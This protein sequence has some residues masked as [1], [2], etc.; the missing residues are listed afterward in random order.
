MPE[1]KFVIESK[2]YFDSNGRM[3]CDTVA[4]NSSQKV[5]K[6]L[7]LDDY[8][9]LLADTR[10]VSVTINTSS[11]Y[12]PYGT[13]ATREGTNG[14]ILYY[15]KPHK[16]LLSYKDK[17]YRVAYPATIFL[18]SKTGSTYVYAVKESSFEKVTTS[19]KLYQ[20][21]FGHVYTS[22]SVCTGSVVLKMGHFSDAPELA[23]KFFNAENSH[24]NNGTNV[25]SILHK[26]EGKDKFPVSLLN[27]EVQN[28]ETTV[29]SLVA[30]Y[31]T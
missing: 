20:W 12:L 14:A 18:F 3:F 2:L 28:K 30:T 25:S 9:N 27:K 21:P 29:G 1:K 7:T 31:F 26:L 22:G 17:L 13:I 4:G 11:G 19:T 15:V 6:T 8:I 24:T 10:K 5:S 23:E 16:G